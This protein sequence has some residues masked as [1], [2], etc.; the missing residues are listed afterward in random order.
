MFAMTRDGSAFI[1]GKLSSKM[2]AQHQIACIEAFNAM[3]ACIKNQARRPALLLLE[4]ELEA[5]DSMRR[6]S[7]YGRSLGHSV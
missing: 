7:L 3:A 5:K 1:V 6:S 2:A 4:K